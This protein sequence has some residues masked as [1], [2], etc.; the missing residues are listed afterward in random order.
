MSVKVFPV[1]SML[2]PL[3][4]FGLE[5]SDLITPNLLAIDAGMTLMFAPESGNASTSTWNPEVFA[6]VI[7][8]L[9][10]GWT[11]LSTFRPF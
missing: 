6:S 3:A 7:E 9:S 5:T 1:I 2:D 4:H 10:S 8:I 11:V